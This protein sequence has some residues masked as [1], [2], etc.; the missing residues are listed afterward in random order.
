MHLFLDTKAR[1]GTQGHMDFAGVFSDGVGLSQMC[2]LDRLE[3]ACIGMGTLLKDTTVHVGY[4]MC[5]FGFP[6]SLLLCH[7]SFLLC[8]TCS[9]CLTEDLS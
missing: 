1:E 7:T 8:W 9:E 5:L 4:S 3:S 2:R 6:L